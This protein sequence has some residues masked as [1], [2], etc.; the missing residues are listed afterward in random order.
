[1]LVLNGGWGIMCSRLPS[2][3]QLQVTKYE[4]SMYN[5]QGYE[6]SSARADR[7]VRCRLILE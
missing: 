7:L 3:N 2:H 4:A 6:R 5:M 1:M